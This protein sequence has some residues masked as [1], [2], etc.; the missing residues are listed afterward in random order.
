MA[1]Y[2]A[3]VSL[4]YIIN[5]IQN[6]HHPP[7]SLIKSQV[8]SL[9]QNLTF[10]QQYLEAYNPLQFSYTK[11][12]DPLEMRIADAAYA[13]EDVIESHIVDQIHAGSKNR[14]KRISSI[15]LYESLQSVI[16]E[17]DSIKKEVVAT[18]EATGVQN[19][20]RRD[21]R[22]SSMGQNPVVGLDDVKLEVMDKLIGGQ[23]NR[24]IITIV[25][26]AGIGKTTLAKN[27]YHD[28]V[29]A[30]NF[31]IL[32]W[33]T[34]TQEHRIREILSELLRGEG[35]GERLSE[36][37]EY[38][39]KERLHK[40]LSGRRYLIVMD[41]IWK[42]EAWEELRKF[43]PDEKNGSRVLITT[44]ISNF[45]ITDSNYV[46]KMGFLDMDYSW[47]LFS[48]IAF[49]EE[50]G[51]P[52]ELEEIGKEIV[53]NCRGLPL[54]IVVVG[55]LL[56]KCEHTREYWVYIAENLNSIVNSEDDEHCLKVLHMSYTQL[57]VHLKPCFLYMGVFPED[58]K[59]HVSKLVRLW[60]AEGFLKPIRGKSLE[61]TAS[62]YLIELID[63]NMVL[64][65]QLRYNGNIKYCN[66]HDLL[67]DLCLREA[68]KESF[69]S[70]IL[71]TSTIHVPQ[72]TS[73]QR[74][75]VVSDSTV[76]QESLVNALQSMSLARS[77]MC[78]SEEILPLRDF[79]LLR[80]MPCSENDFVYFLEDVFQL[81]N[82]RYLTLAARW[83]YEIPSSINLLWNLHT[84]DVVIANTTASFDIW[85]MPQ[86]RHVVFVV[87]LCLPDPPN[88]NIVLE[89]LQK[90]SKIINF[91][92]CDE[93]VKRI[94]NIKKLVMS[95]DNK[96]EEGH[97]DNLGQLQNLESLYC[98][99]GS[100]VDHLRSLTFPHSLKKLTF[101][102]KRAHH[103]EDVMEKIGSLPLL[104][105]L[106]LLDGSFRGRKWET[107]E[108]QFRSLKFLK[109]Q[110]CYDM[111][112][113]TTESTHFPHLEHLGLRGL[114]E[115]KEIPSEVGEM[116]TLKSIKLEMCCSS[117]IISAKK[118]LDDQEEFYGEVG[119]EV[120]V[121][122]MDSEQRNQLRELA[123]PYFQFV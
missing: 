90:L 80:I 13:A 22:S 37:D 36:E 77:L 67:R 87:G 117:A 108:G 94:P 51:C 58:K 10:L 11:E 109:I 121:L 27:I 82:S 96:F 24:Q 118:I 23:R 59:I 99:L 107:V 86:L 74:R 35:D 85:S 49:R 48:K 69:Y 75:V 97:L 46:L 31:D 66:V 95:N 115:L 20:Q 39:L 42:I 100:G 1:A 89:N 83:S 71:Q 104:Q 78:D 40:R 38:D 26:M 116:T 98:R 28:K 8:E 122:I 54:S 29:V 88:G 84:L 30:G 50:G 34:I 91:K 61:E 105:K 70:V 32:G 113:W 6:H 111:E 72:G 114:K 5:Q 101:E 76:S 7:I 60:V 33:A 3:V 55:G 119:I 17:I 68:Q 102:S 4:M 73:A 56:A 14:L 92:C 52:L 63:R 47:I 64:V 21:S 65:K 18:K 16:D 43:F 41:D 112:F 106:R 25:G 9:T 15:D 2:A 53:E 79:R 45:D 12:A 19:Q 103:L 57:P 93:V 81:V 123:S 110:E 62:E 120:Q 44:R